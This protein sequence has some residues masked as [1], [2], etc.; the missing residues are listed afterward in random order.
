MV[1]TFETSGKIL[2]PGDGEL[3]PA[4]VYRW[5]PICNSHIQNSVAFDQL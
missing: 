2:S 3:Y 1:A 5:R 4:V